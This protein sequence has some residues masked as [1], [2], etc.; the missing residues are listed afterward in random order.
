LVSSQQDLPGTEFLGFTLYV[1]MAASEVLAIDMVS[2]PS[3]FSVGPAPIPNN[4]FLIGK[5]YYAQTI[6][7]A[8]CAPMGLG[9]SQALAITIANVN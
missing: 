3:G 2:D 7:L 1:S 4:P 8:A 6:T 5:V 9:A